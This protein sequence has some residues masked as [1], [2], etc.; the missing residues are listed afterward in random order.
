MSDD[1]QGQGHAATPA[2]IL[3]AQIMDSC[4][5]KNEREWWAM[6]EIER[7]RTQ[8]SAAEERETE[9][10]K[11]FERHA[12]II[13][14]QDRQIVAVE[15]QCA[16]MAE[17]VRGIA[18]DLEDAAVIYR[19]TDPL[20]ASAGTCE[21]AAFALRATIDNLPARSVAMG[22]VE[23]ALTEEEELCLGELSGRLFDECQRARK[24]RG[25][26]KT[27]TMIHD[28]LSRLRRR[29]RELSDALLL[30]LGRRVE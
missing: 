15:A 5:P 10:Q 2:A 17:A 24:A 23:P 11:T 26:S 21:R 4:I 7:L 9:H 18:A 27:E 25:E 3:Q 19:N 13:G 22:K 20:S 30:P 6:R 29:H 12:E 16:A 28:S 1:L 8:L 14:E